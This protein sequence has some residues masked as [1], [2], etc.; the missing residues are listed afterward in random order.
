MNA[1]EIFE[2]VLD[3]DTGITHPGQVA[4]VEFSS[5]IIS[6]SSFKD[7]LRVTGHIIVMPQS[8]LGIFQQATAVMLP[9][10]EHLEC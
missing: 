10:G 3:V 7:S 8:L 9:N 6:C 2:L 5:L 1:E 4:E